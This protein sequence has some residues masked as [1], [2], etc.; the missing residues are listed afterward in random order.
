MRFTDGSKYVA[1]IFQGTRRFVS[2]S[3]AVF[4]S[5]REANLLVDFGRRSR[6]EAEQGY[7]PAQ[8]SCPIPHS[9]VAGLMSTIPRA[10]RRSDCP[11][12][13]QFGRCGSYAWPLDSFAYSCSAQQC[14]VVGISDVRSRLQSYSPA[15]R[16]ALASFVRKFSGPRWQLLSAYAAMASRSLTSLS[17]TALA[18]S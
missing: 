15:S 9:I 10:A 3:I 7:T 12:V 1:S 18:L 5:L 6:T 17:L 16:R 14:Y 13:T 2:S 8:S 11:A 4:I